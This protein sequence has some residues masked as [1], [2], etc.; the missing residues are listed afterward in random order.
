MIP[1]VGTRIGELETELGEVDSRM[2][3]VELSFPN[4]PDPDVPVGR[5]DSCNK[6]LRTVGDQVKDD[7][8][9]PHWD[10]LGELM[11][12]DAS[13]AI[14]GANF[15]SAETGRAGSFCGYWGFCA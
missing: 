4:V 1:G 12:Q 10:L 15:I 11:D 2:L 6:V 3:E 8:L 5:D 7:S 14:T 9:L 13:G